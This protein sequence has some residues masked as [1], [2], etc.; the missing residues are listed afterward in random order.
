[1]GG[2]LGDRLARS[3]PLL[4]EEFVHI[5]R[6]IAFQ[7]VIHRARQFMG[8]DRQGFALTMFFRQVREVLLARWVVA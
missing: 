1:M 2:Q 7:H 5:E 6:R 8:E 4:V 3:A